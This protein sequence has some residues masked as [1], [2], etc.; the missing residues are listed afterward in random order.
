MKV[1]SLWQPWASLWVH[2][3]KRIETR[4]WAFPLQLPVVLAVHAAK[5]WDDK[6]LMMAYREA[7][8]DYG[9]GRFGWIA[10]RFHPLPVPIPLVGRQGL[11]N[12]DAPAE[13]QAIADGWMVEARA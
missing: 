11:F 10:D 12:W 1:I 4:S 7:F 2:G 3:L 8:G 9:Q 5:K 13:V 6:Q